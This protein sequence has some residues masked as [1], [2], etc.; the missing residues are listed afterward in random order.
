MSHQS[1]ATEFDSW[2]GNGRADSLEEHH[3]DVVLQVIDKITVGA[4]HKVLD[5]GCGNGWATRIF[6]K[7][8]PG[9]QGIGVDVSP[10][11]IARAEEL[12]VLTHRCRYEVGSFEELPFKDGMFE[13][14]FSME[15]LY[16][17]VDVDKALAEAFRVLKSGGDIDVVIDFYKERPATEGWAEKVPVTMHF[18]GEDEWK[19]RFEKAGFT[20]VATERVVDSRGPGDESA[21]QPNEWYTSWPDKQAMHDA[22]SL[23]IRGKKA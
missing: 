6:G 19:Q 12:H 15:A 20:D 17:A 3:K 2:V 4:G 21:F 14:V 7:I 10:Q 18:L 1:I 9:S 5:L 8:A 22:G 23:W 11:M 16:Y 13:R